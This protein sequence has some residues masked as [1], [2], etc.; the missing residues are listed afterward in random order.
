MARFGPP[1]VLLMEIVNGSPKVWFDKHTNDN[2]KDLYKGNTPNIEARK[3][4]LIL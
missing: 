1:N 4:S 2:F 3:K